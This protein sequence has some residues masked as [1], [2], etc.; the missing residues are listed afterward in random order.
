MRFKAGFLLLL[1]PAAAFVFVPSRGEVKARAV[2]ALPGPGQPA[3]EADADGDLFLVSPVSLAMMGPTGDALGTWRPPGGFEVESPLV[4]GEGAVVMVARATKA[5]SAL[6]TAFSLADG[7]PRQLWTREVADLAAGG[8][9]LPLAAEGGRQVVAVVAGGNVELLGV[10]DGKPLTQ[11]KLGRVVGAVC[12][13]ADSGFVV[14]SDGYVPEGGEP[15]PAVVGFDALPVE[16]PADWAWRIPAGES[17]TRLEWL[18]Q[19]EVLA[20]YGRQRVYVLGN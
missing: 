17:I 13:A 7:T 14:T 3:L 10:A 20:A 2:V 16:D 8:V 18:A 12:W 4:V 6:L 5:P 1:A 19:A 15:G 11:R 9:R